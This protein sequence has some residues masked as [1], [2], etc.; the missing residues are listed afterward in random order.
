MQRDSIDFGAMDIGKLFRKQLIPTVL[1]M[2]F[3]ALFVITDGIFVGRGIGS[4]ALAAVNIAAPLYVFSAGLGLMFGM[5]GAIIASINLSRGKGK[6]ANINVTQAVMV[7][8]IIMILISVFVAVFPATTARI[9]GAPLDIIHL[10]KE[11]LVVYA[12]F[13]VFQTL[14]VICTFFTR[15]DAPKIAMWAMTVSTIINIVL[16]YVFIFI[17]QWGL[18][19]AAAATGLGEI[20]GCVWLLLYLLRKSPR[21]RLQMPKWSKKS[22]LL[23]VRN[24]GYIVKLGFSAFLGEASIG[25]M[26]L[27]GNYIFVHY[28]GTDGV[29]AFS[30]VCYFFPII[31]MVF[32]AIIQ[33]AQP[34]ISYNYGCGFSDRVNQAL[35]LAFKTTLATGTFFILVFSLIRKPLVSLFITD[36]A[37]PA[38]QYAVDGIPYFAS[39]YIFFGIN[40][41]AIGYF[42]SVEQ[43]KRA[44]LFTI[45]RGIVMPVICFF[46]LPL[47]LGVPG[48]WLSVAVAELITLSAIGISYA[49]QKA[50]ENGKL[51]TISS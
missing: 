18:P 46:V 48:I 23:T 4:D 49:R 12:I 2:V 30:I 3:S 13:S 29:A 34:I 41:V 37:N 10:A 36:S 35:K 43:A 22:I 42:M 38:W 50:K 44:T 25:V 20:A 16:D 6:V 24:T 14:L 15:I 8:S 21:I 5:G 26:M 9:L 51:S 47:C 40:V 1:G 33:S 7:S 27:T 28:L 19:G 11:Y 17:F 45:M 32:N 31:Y 39:C